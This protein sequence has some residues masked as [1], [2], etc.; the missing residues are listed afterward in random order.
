MALR[1]EVMLPSPAFA[2]DAASKGHA[3]PPRPVL[4]SYVPPT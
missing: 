1:S 3:L 2:G 4:T